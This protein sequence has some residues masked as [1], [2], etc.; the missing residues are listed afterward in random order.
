MIYPHRV[1]HLNLINFPVIVCIKHYK[2]FIKLRACC[3]V[4]A[5]PLNFRHA[6]Y[7][8]PDEQPGLFFVWPILDAAVMSDD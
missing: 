4:F 8:I 1:H 3:V 5:L 2:H 7:P 6:I